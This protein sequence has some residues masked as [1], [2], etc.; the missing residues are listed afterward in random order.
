MTLIEAVTQIVKA[1]KSDA[2]PTQ[3]AQILRQHGVPGTVPTKVMQ[4]VLAVAK[5]LR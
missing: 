4:T 3:I 2:D 5:V 1:T